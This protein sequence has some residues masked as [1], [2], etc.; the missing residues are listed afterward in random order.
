MNLR[1]P[2]CTRHR[3][4]SAP[5][6]A[7]APSV[8]QPRRTRLLLHLANILAIDAS[9]TIDPDELPLQS[10]GYQEAFHNPSVQRALAL[11]NVVNLAADFWAD[12]GSEVQ[13]VSRR[14]VRGP[15][16]GDE[17]GADIRKVK[18]RIG[19]ETR[20]GAG[21]SRLTRSTKTP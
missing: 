10:E 14:R 16:D 5:R 17:F 2:F 18:R 15:R 8:S 11:A 4:R 13:L 3:P 9:G 1:N 21:I 12:P 7:L 19:D 20:I 6:T